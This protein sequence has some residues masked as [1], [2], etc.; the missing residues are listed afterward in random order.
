MKVIWSG[1]SVAGVGRGGGANLIGGDRRWCQRKGGHGLGLRGGSHRRRGGG[2]AELVSVGKEQG[3]VTG[4]RGGRDWVDVDTG[5]I[6]ST[7][8]STQGPEQ[9]QAA[10]KKRSGRRLEISLSPLLPVS[11]LI[12]SL[13][14]ESHEAHM[15][16]HPYSL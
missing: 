8:C 4:V 6:T 11:I 9:E 1:A 7:I 15:D 2:A 12:D 14:F 3:F 16:V 10:S 13:G 5:G